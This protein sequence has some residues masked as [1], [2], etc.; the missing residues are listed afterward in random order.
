MSQK[1][2]CRLKIC[3]IIV[4][5]LNVLTFT[6]SYIKTL[7]RICLIWK[8]KYFHVKNRICKLACITPFVCF[9]LVRLFVFYQLLLTQFIGKLDSWIQSIFQLLIIRPSIQ[10]HCHVGPSISLLNPFLTK[11]Y[12]NNARTIVR[13]ERVILK[14]THKESLSLI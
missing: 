3:E 11:R 6:I 1:K 14:N 9:F 13:L 5:L 7:N 12:Y 10:K 4:Y 8:L 2:H